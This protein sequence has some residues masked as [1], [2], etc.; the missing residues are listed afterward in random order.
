MLYDEHK[1]MI[2]NGSNAAQMLFKF[3]KLL[4]L[5]STLLLLK[6]Q[7]PRFHNSKMQ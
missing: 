1:E 4:G 5:Q 6:K 7:Q 3:A 2:F